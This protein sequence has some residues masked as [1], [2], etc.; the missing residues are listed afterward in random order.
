MF[1]VRSILRFCDLTGRVD[2]F[3]SLFLSFNFRKQL[4]KKKKLVST[5][6]LVVENHS[7]CVDNSVTFGKLSE[8]SETSFNFRK[9]LIVGMITIRKNS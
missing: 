8:L 5:K 6:N 4:S 9:I 1:G 7:N 3:N 2:T